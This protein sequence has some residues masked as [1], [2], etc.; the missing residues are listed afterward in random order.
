M[1][2][3]KD[4]RSRFPFFQHHQNLVYL[5]SA[6]TALKPSVVLAAEQAYLERF[7][8]NVGRG[9]YPLAETVTGMFESVREKIA[10]FLCA[11]PKEIIFTS[12]TTD[13]INLAAKLLAT[14]VHSKNNI[15][16][17][18]LEHHS[19]FLPWKELAKKSGADLRIAT[20]DKYGALDIRALIDMVDAN[21]KV[22]AFSAVS[23]VT[24]A[25]APVSDIVQSVRKKNPNVIVLID[26]AQA[27]GHIPINTKIW[28]AD[29]IAFSGHKMFAGTGI[30]VLY[31]KESLLKTLA[32]VT[33]G[34]GMVLDACAETPLYK[35]IPFCFEAGTP[36]ISGVFTLGAA[37]DF[38]TE[39]HLD[40]IRAHETALTAY[41]LQKLN[42][43][44][45]DVL[46]VIGPKDAMERGGLIA[47]TLR[48]AHPHDIA[49]LLG[50]QNIC[51]R[52]GEH[53][54]AP[55]HRALSTDATT[56][57]SFSVYNDTNDIDRCVMTLSDIYAVLKK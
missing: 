30:G 50:E 53:C 39:L 40:Q 55:L 43:V 20:I 14:Q 1:I 17:T 52:A 32:P 23:N 11:Q 16:T 54:A 29:F 28:D 10:R 31:G 15:V 13:S 41:A 49:H 48:G 27:I 5:D 44:F 33:F 4:I 56:R 18:V 46:N 19:N 7:S 42:N 22:V 3:I 47:F 36:N 34:G 8:T 26:A 57:M 37:L 2:P 45:G 21:T 9:L 25:I 35:D 38:I 12:G 24:G 51:V 6:A